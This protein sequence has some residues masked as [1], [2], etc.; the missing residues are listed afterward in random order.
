MRIRIGFVTNSSSSSYIV[1]NITNTTKNALDLLREAADS[2]WYLENWP[3]YNKGSDYTKGDPDGGDPKY[4]A[5]EQEF[6]EEVASLW[7]FPPRVPVEIDIAWG[8]GGPIYMPEGGLLSATRS[9]RIKHIP[10]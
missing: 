7:T 3:H 5:S 2:E 10:M 1:T 4:F 6:L 9:F 8:D